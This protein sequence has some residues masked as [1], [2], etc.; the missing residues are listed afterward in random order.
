M[1]YRQPQYCITCWWS[2]RNDSA[3]PHRAI[4]QLNM[5]AVAHQVHNRANSTWS[6]IK[7]LHR[8]ELRQMPRGGLIARLKKWIIMPYVLHRGD[9][10]L[11]RWYVSSLCS[12]QESLLRMS[13]SGL[14]SGLGVL[15]EDSMLVLRHLAVAKMLAVRLQRKPCC[16]PEVRYCR[17]RKGGGWCGLQHT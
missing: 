16:S 4:A 15:K 2:A 1:R 12:K 5:G 6:V 10:N 9:T 7:W 14:V 11:D 3:L 13:S 8:S 17:R